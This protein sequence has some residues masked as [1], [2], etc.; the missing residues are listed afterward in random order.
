MMHTN[1]LLIFLLVS[2]YNEVFTFGSTF[3]LIVNKSHDK[4]KANNVL[5]SVSILFNSLL[6]P[7]AF[8][9]GLFRQKYE[10]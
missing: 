5:V 9:T 7:S 6:C 2:N 1:N 4:T 10:F 8:K 3:V